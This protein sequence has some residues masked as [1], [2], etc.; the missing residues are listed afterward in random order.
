MFRLRPQLMIVVSYFFVILAGAYLLS[1]PLASAQ[2]LS[3]RPL[4]ALFIASSAVCDSGLTTL[5]LGAHFS[6]FGLTVI[7]VL[8]QL[9][10]LGLMTFA[11]FMVIAF[12]Q[13]LFI[14]QK[15]AIQEALNIYSARDVLSVMG[16]ILGVVF[17][18]E[19]IGA[20]V[21]FWRWLPQL[22]F[23]QA[24][25][26]GVFHSIAAFNNAGFALFANYANLTAYVTDPVINLTI[27]VLAVSGG[28]GFIVIADLLEHRRASLHTKV[29]II[30][31]LILIAL[32]ALVIFLVEYHNPATLAPLSLG[33]KLMTAFFQAVTARTA[34]L[35]T[36]NIGQYLPATAL[37]TMLL[38]FIG[39]SPGGTGGGIKT[40]TFALVLATIAATLKGK[41][42]TNIFGRRLPAET[43]R[44]AFAVVFLA[45]TAIAL[46]IFCLDIT[47]HLALLPLS[48]EV[49]SAFSSVGLSMGITPYL[50]SIGKIIIIMVMLVG[51]IGPLIILLSLSLGQ[52][53]TVVE[54]PK[55]GVAIV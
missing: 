25:F 1:L 9:G 19:A 7:I 55:E 22:G 36:L 21:L 16:R 45:L 49:I 12:R 13:R 32:G 27:A 34:G 14:P 17:F 44:R 52:K 54:P 35:H 28:L 3:T 41:R 6:F 11:T 8:V 42:D 47:E 43:V 50:S 51:R 53:E 15:L 48:F 5:D 33:Q 37:F 24:L 10:G 39:A 26:H 30:T 40:T 20:L 38:M 2:G 23:G 18:F 31:S 4:D 29:V 46:A